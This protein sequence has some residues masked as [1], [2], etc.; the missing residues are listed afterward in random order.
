MARSGCGCTLVRAGRDR[1]RNENN[2]GEQV[3]GSFGNAV[4]GRLRWSDWTGCCA[5]SRR[6]RWEC[7]GSK[8]SGRAEAGDARGDLVSCRGNRD[9][10]QD[11]HGTALRRAGY[12][13]P[14]CCSECSRRGAA[15][16]WTALPGGAH[17]AEHTESDDHDGHG[18]SGNEHSGDEPDSSAQPF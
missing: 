12:R 10:R 18:H 11:R 2:S 15:A 5:L 7:S 9:R 3:R 8:A 1:G 13:R 6:E 14:G 17:D 16:A 4:F